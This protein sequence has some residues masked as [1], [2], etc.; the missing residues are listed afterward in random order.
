[1]ITDI[2]SLISNQGKTSSTQTTTTSNVGSIAKL[3]S[4]LKLID[5]L[6]AIQITSVK[7]AQSDH[8]NKQL[9]GITRNDQ[10]QYT[11]INDKPNQQI[12]AG[13][14]GSLNVAG[15]QV[16]LTIASQR[17]N[18]TSSNTQQPLPSQT[19]GSS[20]TPQPSISYASPSSSATINTSSP[21]TNTPT[22]NQTYTN[23]TR[24]DV[25]NKS[26][27]TS[28]QATT[29]AQ[30][31]VASRPITLTV[32]RSNTS[33]THQANTSP[34]KPYGIPQQAN[35]NN[36]QD[37]A[38]KTTSRLESPT[39][40]LNKTTEAVAKAST[41]QPQANNLKVNSLTNNS[42]SINEVSAINQ[43][44]TNTPPEQ[45]Q[46]LATERNTQT[47]VQSGYVQ[48]LNT[49][50]AST[51]SS[52]NATQLQTNFSVVVSDGKEEFILNTQHP[53]KEGEKLTVVIDKQG[54]M[55]LY[56]AEKTSS[57][58]TTLT[59]SL[60]Q[61]L[62]KQITPQEFL[63]MIRQLNTLSQSGVALPEKVAGAL[64]QLVKQLPNIQNL[65]QSGEGIK[66]AIQNS[67]LFSENNLAKNMNIATDF[68]LNLSRLDVANQ[69]V[70]RQANVTGVQA[71]NSH[72]ALNLVAGAI[73]RITTNQ[74]RNL[75]ENAQQDGS[76][77]P[78]S[79]EIPIKDGRSTSVVNINIDQDKSGNNEDIEPHK[80]RWLVQ[81]KFDFEETGRF[82]A[83]T[84]IQDK[85]VGI[86]FAVEEADTERLIREHLDELRTSLRNRQVEIET[87]DCFRA[88]LQTQSN[89]YQEQ[90]QQRLIDVRT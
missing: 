37:I 87:L 57:T 84:S 9:I 35:T 73:E 6:H 22:N 31:V 80:R 49:A 83:R 82:E 86:I 41:S 39:S 76:I 81:L 43:P 62:P 68:K 3:S 58:T 88:N 67:G 23:Q 11:L 65:T 45:T 8:G 20:T 26:T 12:Q 16:S 24:S 79:V 71:A 48:P 4:E 40:Q 19:T 13:D 7:N 28:Q 32:I 74:V 46:P 15:N 61:T 89:Q 52:T 50:S 14:K 30:V 25:A 60:R 85:K 47:N 21:N 44:L 72:Q 77:L 27:I 56:P 90:K 63:S 55:Q 59:E 78:L 70:A 69:D 5:G 18:Q 64:E 10:Q 51:V 1:M 42:A 75:I 17:P 66:Q 29:I 36:T 34:A 54:Q 2:N 38:Q 33:A 53:I